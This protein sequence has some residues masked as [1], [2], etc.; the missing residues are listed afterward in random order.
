[1]KGMYDDLFRDWEKSV[2]SQETQ[3]Q[4]EQKSR[5]AYDSIFE[6]WQNSHVN[7]F[8][9]LVENSVESVPGNPQGPPT[10]V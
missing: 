9:F 3:Y 10:A 6:Q 2:N 8:Q 1:M 4:R 5:E 7:V